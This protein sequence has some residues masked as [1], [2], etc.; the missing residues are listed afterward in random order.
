LNKGN[1]PESKPIHDFHCK[2]AN[3]PQTPFARHRACIIS[4]RKR[5]RYSVLW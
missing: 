2:A 4:Q 1:K 5:P 3:H